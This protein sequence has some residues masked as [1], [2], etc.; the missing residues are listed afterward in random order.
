MRFP[1]TYIRLMILTAALV[2]LQALFGTHA[3]SQDVKITAGFNQTVLVVN[4]EAIL[5]VEINGDLNKLGG[6]EMP[7]FGEYFTFNG[8]RGSSRNIQIINGRMESSMTYTYSLIPQKAGKV[9]IPAVKVQ[10][11]NKKYN[12]NEITIEIKDTGY[13]PPQQ[14][15]AQTQQGTQGSG[16]PLD[17]FVLAVPDKKSIF[18]NEGVTVEYKVYIGPGINVSEYSLENLPNTAGFW[19]EDYP[20]SRPVTQSEIYNNK[21][22]TT[23][24]LKRVEL[25]PTNAGEFELDPMQIQFSVQEPRTSRS[26]SSIDRF[27]DD[28]FFNRSRPVNI[29]STGLKL[30]VKPLPVSGKPDGFT[31]AV[32]RYNTAIEVDNKTVKANESITIKVTLSGTGNIKLLNEPKLNIT[33]VYEQYDPQVSETINRTESDITGKKIYEYVIV[34][35]REGKLVIEPIELAFFDPGSEVY[36]IAKTAPV[37]IKVTPGDVIASNT[38]RNLTRNEIKLIGSDVRFIKESVEEWKKIGENFYTS[39]SFLTMLLFPVLIVGGVFAY[40]R[41]LNR[42][43]ADIGYKRSRRANAIAVKH[44]KRAKSSMDK[45]DPDKFYPELANALQKYIAD[46]LNISAAGLLTDEI[47]KILNSKK[48]DEDLVKDYIS[49]LEQCDFHRFASAGSGGDGMSGL[50]EQAAAAITNMEDRLKKTG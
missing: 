19:T 21:R 5:S 10:V 48:V 37:S 47:E 11:G 23:A 13:T 35:R 1:N 46:R 20:I 49:C 36:R 6:V 4:Q 34:P 29:N 17:L 32:G 42:L 7:N 27:F 16:Q 8:S 38:P 41:H 15:R 28:P 25:F 24:V 18:E 26:R 14:Q 3:I 22:Y 31:G 43:N 30:L 44:L 9:K 12:S 40:S 45:N 33:G 50:Y 2:T 39:F